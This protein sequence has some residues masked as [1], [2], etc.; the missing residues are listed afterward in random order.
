MSDRVERNRHQDAADEDRQRGEAWIA[1]G[2][3]VA[4]GFDVRRNLGDSRGE[5]AVER[6]AVATAVLEAHRE[7]DDLALRGAERRVLE[8]FEELDH[9][10]QRGGRSG[11]L[12]ERRG[13]ESELLALRLEDGA[14]GA[15]S[16]RFGEGLK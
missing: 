1:Q 2:I 14:R 4:K 12:G 13:Q 6:H 11:E 3:A 10:G 15:W 7:C 8:P 5:G 9:R 16:I